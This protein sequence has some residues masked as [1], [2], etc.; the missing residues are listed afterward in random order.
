MLIIRIKVVS[1]CQGFWEKKSSTDLV[2][3]DN[4]YSPMI[5]EA[6]IKELGDLDLSEVSREGL[7][8][9]AS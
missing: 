7:F 5:L 9:A 8:F 6:E 1:F 4:I 3:Y 2:A